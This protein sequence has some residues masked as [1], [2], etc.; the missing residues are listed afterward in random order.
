MVDSSV[1]RNQAGR[2]SIRDI[3]LRSASWTILGFGTSQFL[4]LAGNLILTRLLLPEHFGLMALLNVFVQ[5]LEM[6]SDTGVASSIVRHPDGDNTEFLDAAWTLQVVRGAALWLIATILAWPV[7]AFYNEPAIRVLMPVLALEVVVAGF[8][9]TSLYTASRN[10]MVKRLVFMEVLDYG[11][12]L[13]ATVA[14]ALLYKS[15]WAFVIGG[16]IGAL[17]KACLS[18]VMLERR[19]HRFRI[20]RRALSELTQFGRWIFVS[21]AFGFLA[22]RGDRLIVGKFVPMAKL[23]VYSIAYWLAAFMPNALQAVSS[24]LLFPLYSRLAEIHIDELRGR[25]WKIRACILLV[26]VPPLCA[27]IV[28]GDLVVD[29]LYEPE[30][31]AAGPMLQVLSAGAL[32]SAV[33]LTLS[34][35]LLALGDSFKF[36]IVLVVK[37]TM[38]V[39]LMTVGGVLGANLEWQTAM[40]GGG[41]SG[42]IVGLTVSNYLTYIPL[43]VQLRKKQIW[44]WRIDLLTLG[45]AIVLVAAGFAVRTL[46]DL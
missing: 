33:S 15:V 43:A 37:L 38:M 28:G 12:G 8:N 19:R 42:M 40:G 36:M 17:A 27:L 14:L 34:P 3:F 10:L 11:I 41:L 26:A 1:L 24:R 23:G 16:V 32:A 2:I 20:N 21:T 31:A 39:V 7:A 4:R 25:I 35:L 18:H 30:W 9:S 46:F 22:T 5:G 6:F 45:A 44:M 29:F 13:I